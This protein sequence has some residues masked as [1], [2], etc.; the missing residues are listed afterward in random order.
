MTQAPQ[1]PSWIPDIEIHRAVLDFAHAGRPKDDKDVMARPCS[2]PLE[3]K[4]A[5]GAPS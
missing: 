1:S 4:K 3:V 2:E 5:A